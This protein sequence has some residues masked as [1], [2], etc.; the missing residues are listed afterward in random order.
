[1]KDKISVIGGPGT[2][3]TTLSK[4]LKTIYDLPIIH[5]DSIRYMR[6]WI[7]RDKEE[8]KQI[9]LG[10]VK[11][12]K[13]IIE[14]NNIETLKERTDSADLTIWLDY[15]TFQQ[16]KGVLKRYFQYHHKER[17][18]IPGCNEKFDIRFIMYILKYNR[19]KKPVIQNILKES[20]KNVLII[21]SRK[22][23]KKWLSTIEKY[24]RNEN[25]RIKFE[26]K[27]NFFGDKKMRNIK[28]TI[29]YNGYYFHGWQRLPRYK[30]IQGE[31]EKTLSEVLGEPIRI[32]GS[33]R[34]DA[35]VHALGQVANFKTNANIPLNSIY[36]LLNMKLNRNIGIKSLEE[37]D[38][39]F[40]AR[41]CVKIKTYRYIINNSKNIS[42]IY[43]NYE[44]HMPK[45]LDVNLMKE[46]AKYL[47]GEHD[48][49]A[50]K[51]PKLND[52]NTTRTIY[53]INIYQQ[54]DR[55]FIE[56]SGN[57]F[58]YNMVRIISGTL[59]DVGLGK[60]KPQEIKDM[61]ASK[62]RNTSGRMLP[63]FGLYLY[64]VEY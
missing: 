44:Y 40:H 18:E 42:P 14:G 51:T 17:E 32:N 16:L 56:V 19:R 5:I 61:L 60:I 12:K 11:K 15:S 29:E 7:D 38:N 49:K 58:L 28:M 54:D 21:K 31:I 23:L 24:E 35:G 55:I 6:G 46:A 57:G 37:V 45:K 52:Y 26:K 22:E 34:T 13:W 30:T 36:D 63:P 39:S 53:K 59:V 47:E 64:K 43:K 62:S 3:K 27:K 50:F 1:M 20:N 8:T 48:F 41:Y 10:E 33:G 2:G 9:I 25:Q 4:Q